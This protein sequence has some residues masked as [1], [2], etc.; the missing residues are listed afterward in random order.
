[1]IHHPGN[2]SPP[3]PTL[4][5][6][7]SSEWHTTPGSKMSEKKYC[8]VVTLILAHID[9]YYGPEMETGI[10]KIVKRSPSWCGSNN[11]LSTGW[12][13]ESS[14][15]SE[16][17]QWLFHFCLPVRYFLFVYKFKIPSTFDFQRSVLPCSK[18]WFLLRSLSIDETFMQGPAYENA[19][20][21]YRSLTWAQ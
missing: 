15:L 11:A 20:R 2:Y 12:G 21:L 19:M 13:T 18:V 1:M 7:P 8:T 17:N 14:I 4:L 6:R 3:K 16:Q 5:K 9:V 10:Y